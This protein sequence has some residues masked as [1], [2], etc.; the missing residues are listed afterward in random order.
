MERRK[1]INC[2]P[3]FFCF[4]GP[5][6]LRRHGLEG[7][8]PTAGL[9]VVPPLE[10]VLSLADCTGTPGPRP[11]KAPT[12]GAHNRSPRCG[13]LLPARKCGPGHSSAPRPHCRKPS[14]AV[15][16]ARTV[17]RT[18]TSSDAPRGG[19]MRPMPWAA[20]APSGRGAA[21]DSAL[22]CQ[23]GQVPDP[24]P[25]PV[26]GWHGVVPAMGSPGLCSS[27]PVAP[28]R[29]GSPTTCAPM[30][31][32]L[33]SARLAGLAER[34]PARGHG[35]AVARQHSPARRPPSLARRAAAGRLRPT[36]GKLLACGARRPAEQL[37]HEPRRKAGANPSA[38]AARPTLRRSRGP[39]QAES[40]RR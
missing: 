4:R 37:H 11:R 12:N 20:A 22:R 35:A 36:P 7:Q 17:R 28:R 10:A 26:A 32:T 25:G 27:R 8:A 34:E 1:D 24:A 29:K 21:G 31:T 3:V 9:S 15:G 2:L 33:R 18:R 16:R 40:L 6:S 13:A 14:G 23:Q 38:R 5:F 39:R 30:P 19:L